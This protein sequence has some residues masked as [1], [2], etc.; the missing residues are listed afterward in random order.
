MQKII[1][2]LFFSLWMCSGC[3]NF[4]K[5]N[6]DHYKE[7]IAD[8]HLQYTQYQYININSAQ[9]YIDS[10]HILSKIHNYQKGLGMA[11]LDK[12]ELENIKG[13]YNLSLV[14]EEKALAIFTNHKDDTFLAQTWG[15]IGVNYW[16]RGIHDK[17]LQFHFQAC[18]LN[19]KLGLKNEYAA[20]YNRISMV[21]Q[22]KEDVKNAAQFASHAIEIIKDLPPQQNHANIY[23][24]MAN[25]YGMQGK[26]K[27]AM[28]LDSIG[29]SICTLLNME[30]KKSM[31]YDNIANCYYFMKNSDSSI[32]YH[33]KAIAID[34]TFNNNKLLGDTY[35]S[36]GNIYEEKKDFIKANEYY[37]KSLE[38]C[39][40]TGYKTGV[41]IALE[42]LS[43]LAYKQRKTTD[44]YH[45]L[46]QSILVKDSMINEA[47]EKQIAEMQTVFDTEKKK[48][49]IEQQKIKISRRNISIISLICVFI[50]SLIS[51]LM[52]YN[53]YKWKQE[54][55]LQQELLKE[56]EK[57]AKAILE[58]EENE[59]QRLAREL[60]DGVGQLLSVTKLNLSAITADN[61]NKLNDSIIILDDSIKEIRNIS[62]NMAPDILQKY[63][64]QRAIDDFVLRIQ[65]S[66]KTNIH[67]ESNGFIESSLNDTDKLMLYRI[68]QEAVNNSLKYGQSENIMIQLSADVH[69]I[70]LLIEDNGK[71]FDINEVKQKDGIGLRNM[72]LRTEVLKGR[73]EIDS[74]LNKGTTIIVEIPLS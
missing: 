30:F 39:R 24:N 11:F 16:H 62:H 34:S 29:L 4:I 51:Y 35:N 42:S 14:N 54:Q 63:G 68:I 56:E 12:G 66:K 32:L 52:W 1:Q 20:D 55:K 45:L 22:T 53:R 43:N 40:L 64:L 61:N 23:H 19:E 15:A 31:F 5:N 18:K 33:K 60:H 50:L 7:K 57:R 48:Q 65:Q 67:F 41:K 9:N 25:I 27:E 58:S 21:Y 71:G 38:L 28:Q 26:Y 2:S 73:I 49:Q 36:L 59:R 47:S 44:A 8:Y 70:S 69:E 10:I 3:T 72:Q 6:N 17:A 46:Q 13:N 74:A 37:Q